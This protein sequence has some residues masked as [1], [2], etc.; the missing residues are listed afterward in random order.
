MAW[1]DRA[2]AT[3]L[4]CVEVREK[5]WS[6]EQLP[7][8]SDSTGARAERKEVTPGLPEE[9]SLS[10]GVGARRSELVQKADAGP[11]AAKASNEPAVGRTTTQV[12]P[13]SARPFDDESAA[14]S[15]QGYLK[16]MLEYEITHR[17]GYETVASGCSQRVVVEL[18]PIKD[19]YTVF[20][21]YTGFEREEKVD[22]VVVQEFPKLA[23]RIAR[24]LLENRAISETVSRQDVLRADNE[25]RLRTVGVQGHILFGLGTTLRLAALPT[26]TADGRAAERELR[27]LT[28]ADIQLGYRGKFQAW[29]LDAFG[30]LELGTRERSARQNP[31]GGHADYAAQGGLGLHYLRY[32]APEE[33]SSLYVGGGATF[34]TSFYRVIRSRERRDTQARDTVTATGLELDALVGYEFLRASAVYFFLQGELRAPTYL[35]KF[36]SG[37]SLKNSYVPGFGAEIGMVF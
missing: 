21:R 13:G 22:F 1:T 34:T 12:E 2:R 6:D 14:F 24:A 5:A 17:S 31:G 32:F 20:A 28:P 3:T 4:V 15:P 27:W 18:Y 26:A 25:G 23:S 8:G 16:R 7:P 33:M 37:N 29:G 30:R 36:E 19:G 11:S 10:P 35:V 9:R